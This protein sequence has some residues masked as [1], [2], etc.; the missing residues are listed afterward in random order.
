M[1]IPKCCKGCSLRNYGTCNCT[2]PSYCN[3]YVED[4]SLITDDDK[5]YK[6]IQYLDLAGTYGKSI[7]DNGVKSKN[8]FTFG[9][10][11]HDTL[12][13]ETSNNNSYLIYENLQNGCG[14][15]FCDEGYNFLDNGNLSHVDYIEP[16]VQLV[17]LKKLIKK[18]NTENGIEELKDENKKLRELG[19]S[20]AE[21]VEL[22]YNALRLACKQ[23]PD[24]KNPDYFIELAKRGE[25]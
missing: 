12:I 17:N 1:L 8:I 19:K 20:Y 6:S 7:Q 24:I 18:Y 5:D 9:F 2:L 10:N 15:K 14:S 16:H 22:V 3:E 21:Q 25:E 13:I 23:I 11:I 4:D